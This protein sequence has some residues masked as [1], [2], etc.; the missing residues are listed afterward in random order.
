M[1]IAE[2]WE[3]NEVIDPRLGF[4]LIAFDLM[5]DKNWSGISART[6]FA[7]WAWL[8]MVL[9]ALSNSLNGTNCGKGSGK[10]KIQGT[11]FFFK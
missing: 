6:S 1:E 9:P 5:K 8:I 7:S 11:F 10:K 3:A 2:A 4:G